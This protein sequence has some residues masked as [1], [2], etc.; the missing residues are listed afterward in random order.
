[1]LNCWCITW[2]VGFK[3]LITDAVTNFDWTNRKRCYPHLKRKKTARK[4]P[5][6]QTMYFLCR[7]I[8]SVA[9]RESVQLS[10]CKHRQSAV[11]L[12]YVHQRGCVSRLCCLYHNH[13][14]FCL[15]PR[16]SMWIW[17]NVTSDGVVL[18]CYVKCKLGSQQFTWTTQ[19]NVRWI[20]WQLFFA[21]L[22][23]WWWFL[24]Y[25]PKQVPIKP[26]T[27]QVLLYYM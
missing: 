3:N 8:H 4:F 16:C 22:S 26:D 10:V 25:E 2:P 12:A 21:A 9:L 14:N 23:T 24:I 27:I 20:T 7:F 13:F 5:M 19:N 6:S 17:R 1:M 11:V 18:C 15:T